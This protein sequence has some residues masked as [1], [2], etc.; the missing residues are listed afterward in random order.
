MHL[1]IAPNN[2]EVVGLKPM[3]SPA[4][5]G[6]NIGN[7]YLSASNPI[8]RPPS[9]R[10]EGTQSYQSFTPAYNCTVPYSHTLIWPLRI[11]MQMCRTLLHMRHSRML[12]LLLPGHVSGVSCMHRKAAVFTALHTLL[13]WLQVINYDT[14]L[15]AH[16]T[17]SATFNFHD[18]K[19][20]DQ[21]QAA[22]RNI[23]NECVLC[24]NDTTGAAGN[25]RC[26]WL[27]CMHMIQQLMQAHHTTRHHA[28]GC[29]VA[30]HWRRTL[31]SPRLPMVS[32][33]PT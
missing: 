32:P 28:A 26:R 22:I 23:W 17:L 20:N 15:P 5:S 16:Y 25:P 11:C 9:A 8:A 19:L 24:S 29:A 2:P 3:F 7:I 6:G 18:V 10:I 21:E 1:S 4:E 27:P 31:R 14:D 30:G 33:K 12:L 13:Y